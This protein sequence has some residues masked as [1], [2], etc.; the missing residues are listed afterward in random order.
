[1]RW[2]VGVLA[3]GVEG[4]G[5]V[6]CGSSGGGVESGVSIVLEFFVGSGI[7]SMGKESGDKMIDSDFSD[8]YVLSDGSALKLIVENLDLER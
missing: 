3:W 7:S 1:M 5:R 2:A 8:A 6:S 4:G